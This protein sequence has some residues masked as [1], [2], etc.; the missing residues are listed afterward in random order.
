MHALITQFV[1]Q[2]ERG[3]MSRRDLITALTACASA[4]AVGGVGGLARAQSS[5]QA[6]PPPGSAP[7]PGAAP[8][9]KA[10][11]LNHIALS[12][13]DVPRARDWYQRHLGLRVTSDGG[14]SSCF[15]TTGT[16]WV[17]LFRGEKPGMHHYCYSI[18]NYDVAKAEETLRAA[19]LKPERQGGRIYF[20][21]PDGLI[22]QL[23]AK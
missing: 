14:A 4:V 9:F 6:S 22:V 12:V 17:A 3:Q 18:D 8:A 23:A 21:D 10:V 16:G 2:F 20:P 19:G 7:A 15:L 5:T 13:T 1:N 11:D